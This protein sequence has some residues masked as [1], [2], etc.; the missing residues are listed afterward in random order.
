LRDGA[1]DPGG[2]QVK[3]F[4]DVAA[5]AAVGATVGNVLAELLIRWWKRRHQ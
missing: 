5:G 1:L 2:L 4:F 3:I